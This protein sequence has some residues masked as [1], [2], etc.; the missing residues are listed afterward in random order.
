VA[1]EIFKVM[2]GSRLSGTVAV[3]GAKNSVL[4]LM[5]AA[6]L[7]PGVT[8]LGN[9]PNIADVEIMVEL[10]TR[11]GCAVTH[12]AV[13]ATVEIDV[14]AE[15]G[16]RA[17][18]D[19]VRRMR[20]SI[21]VLGPILAR[22][23]EVDVALPG[24]DDIG[25]RGVDMHIAGLTKMGAEFGNDH[26]YLIARAPSG[27]HGAHIFLDLPS[28][29]ATENILTAAVLA[30]G[31]TVLDNAARE[32]E[33]VDLCEMLINMGAQISGVGTPTLTIT[34]VAALKPV[35]H[36]VV[37]DR[38]VAGTWAAA[39]VLTGGEI[40]VTGINPDHLALPLSKLHEM[41]AEIS[42]QPMGFSV[43]MAKRP[44]AV[45]IV[46]LPYPGFPTDLQPQFIVINAIAA[47][48]AM[49]TENLFEA[50]FR[51]TQELAR[52]GAD[53]HIDG[54]HCLVKGVNKLSGAPVIATD[55]RAGAALVLAGLIADGET[56]VSGVDHVDRG[57]ANFVSTL[58]SLGASITREIEA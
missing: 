15:I 52:L 12:D 26:G 3:P 21:N 53:L 22:C 10:L 34:G 2:G 46:T 47:G 5:T 36:Q 48:S 50:R 13:A 57:Y 11:L 6:L 39:A 20:A 43:K 28:V 35:D 31:E 18:Y 44:T 56:S 24:G 30:S 27:L 49:V 25:S 41:G 19:L 4:K 33:I 23:G 37:G 40:T 7:A 51:F 14:P 58:N 29:G 55:V 54:H 16:H 32:P 38:I 17:D 1:T 9:V 45:D 42:T 8:K